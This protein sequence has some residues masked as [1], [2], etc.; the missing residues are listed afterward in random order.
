MKKLVFFE[1]E[2]GVLGE[3]EFPGCVPHVNEQVVLAHPST[4]VITWHVVR[5]TWDI[6]GGAVRI[7]V[8]QKTW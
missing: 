2:R 8:C 4:G 7:E 5:V 3:I 1:K 6:D